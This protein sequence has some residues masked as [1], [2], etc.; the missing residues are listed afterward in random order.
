MTEKIDSAPRNVTVGGMFSRRP[1]ER[2]SKWPSISAK[3]PF[4]PRRRRLSA[5]AGPTD[6]LRASI[7]FDRR[8]LIT[9]GAVCQP[10]RRPKVPSPLSGHL[11]APAARPVSIFGDSFPAGRGRR[12]DRC[13]PK[14]LFFSAA[15]GSIRVWEGA[16]LHSASYSPFG[17]KRN[18]QISRISS[19]NRSIRIIFST[20]SPFFYFGTPFANTSSCVEPLDGAADLRPS[21]RLCER[22]L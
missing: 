15:V 20:F 18:F 1:T 16:C 8:E 7:I 12:G 2:P 14:P 13:R 5:S 22:D 3:P 6:G 9:V 17:D 4:P 11:R 19:L 10:F 21:G